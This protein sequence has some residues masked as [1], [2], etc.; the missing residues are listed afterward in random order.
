M[1]KLLLIFFLTLFVSSIF[2][3]APEKL[4]SGEIYRS[5]EKLNFLGSALYIAAHPDDENT[6][7][8]SHLSNEV[9]ANTAYLSLTRG[10][11]GQNRIGPEIRELLG[12][13]RTHE[14]LQARKRDGGQ[15][16]F[17]RANDFGYSKHPKETFAIWNKE[18][19][20]SDIVRIIRKFKPDVIIN[21]FDHKTPGRTHGHHTGSAML[22]VESFDLTGDKNAYPYQLKAL[23]PWTPQRIYFNTS[24][25]FYGSRD[26]FAKADKSKLVAVDIG[27]YLTHRGK[28]NNE[29]AAESRSQH[30]SQGFG[31]TGTRGTE[32]EYLEVVKGDIPDDNQNIF[33]GVNTTWSRVKKGKHITF[34]INELLSNYNF[35]KPYL[36]VSALLKVRKQILNVKDDHWKHIKRAEID[37][38][39]VA[40]TA[41]FIEFKADQEYINPGKNLVFRLEAVNRS[42]VNISIHSIQSGSIGVDTTLNLSLTENRNHRIEMTSQTPKSL[43]FTSPYWLNETGTL[44]MYAVKDVS[45]RGKPE[46]PKPIV[47]DVN[48]DVDGTLVKIQKDLIYKY[49]DPVKGEV[50]RPFSVLPEASVSL[51][52]DVM[53][54]SGNG[55]Q[56]ITVKVKAFN[57]KVEGDL[58]I[59]HGDKWISEP[60]SHKVSLNKKNQEAFYTFRITPPKN[61]ESNVISPL[62]KVNET[63]TFQKELVEI[64]Y[65]HIPYQT[66][67]HNSQ[68]RVVK[69]NIEKEGKRIAYIEGAGDEVAQGLRQIGYEV[70]EYHPDD[71]AAG[72]L[73][74]YDACLV[75]IR[76][77]NVHR[78][79]KVKNDILFDFAKNGGTV[80]IQYQTNRGLKGE[81]V[82]PLP[83]ELGRD[84]VTDEY[85][86]V[87][88]INP[89]HPVLNTPNKLTMKDFEGW[90]QERG[91][92][93]P[94][95]WGSEYETVLGMNDKGQEQT[96]S[97]ILIGKYGKGHYIYTGISFFREMPAGVPGA[98][99]LLA[100][101]ISIQ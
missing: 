97:S 98:Y 65:D 89:N 11:G 61:Q 51:D 12:V 38:I 70:D 79:M 29:I 76:A 17:T 68:A 31:S 35:N 87:E 78:A 8:I 34:M 48:L 57:N 93:F 6:R 2:S 40:A 54:F 75:G 10:D 99:R 22:S 1:N 58:E 36:S 74:G 82:S 14:L 100:N 62:L 63:T 7:L 3:Q 88:F 5:I 9:L 15:Q 67:L 59:C 69:L 52:Q 43:P 33:D 30:K 26:N 56:N 80:I 49:N 44:G 41:T 96:K 21:R 18:E 91:L 42:P 85:S 81:I 83:L 77:F 25:W 20:L 71:L 53:I 72:T 84:R 23:K 28:S 50:Y 13:M 95:K 66:V 19:V 55:S 73:D 60:K 47:F 16:F 90:V 45:L 64:D 46:N 27:G 39:L 101:L 37:R 86:N 94:K 92:Y 32:M 4:T 24:W